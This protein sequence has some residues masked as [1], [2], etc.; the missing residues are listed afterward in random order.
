DNGILDHYL[1]YGTFTNPGCYREFIKQLPDSV[2]ELGSLICHQVIH[3]S[4]LKNGNIKANRDLRYG[5]MNDFPWHRLRCE[6]D[7]LTTAVSMIAELL[8][9]D[10]NGFTANRKVENKIVVTCR[11]VSILIASILKTKGI[12]CRVRSGFATYFSEKCTDH[13]INQYWNSSEQRWIAID[14]DFFADGSEGF[15]QFDIPE[16]KFHW[17]ADVW[18]GIR[19]GTLNP[20]KYYNAGGFFGLMPTLWELFYDFH[21]L[22]NNEILYMQEPYY[23]QNKFEQL[24]EEEYAEIDKLAELLQNPDKN[25]YQL[26]TLWDTEKKFR[27]LNGPLIG[28]KDHVLW[29]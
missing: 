18:L 12:P 3:R 20:D 8:R 15:D 24:T 2:S 7:I 19:N 26:L 27:I 10:P 17:A 25:Y 16:E 28:D 23:I 1:E 21:S 6:D 11:Y 29:K 5:D 9:L 13:W 22:M 14:A 4:I